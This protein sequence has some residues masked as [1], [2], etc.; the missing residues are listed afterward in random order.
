MDEATVTT[1]LDEA[2]LVVGSRTNPFDETV[3]ADLYAYDDPTPADWTLKVGESP[4]NAKLEQGFAVITRKWQT[5]DVVELDLPM[6]VRKVHGHA[7][8]LAVRGDAA[9]ERGPVLYC[10]EGMDSAAAPSALTVSPDAV[11]RAE[12]KPDLLGGV[13]TLAVSDRGTMLTAIPYFAWNNR[14][15]APMAVWLKR[16]E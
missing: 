6:P 4:V 7:A 3:P 11:I 5:G 15:L 13:T 16:A 14:G 12:V 8:I 2:G 1:R 9:L 10:V